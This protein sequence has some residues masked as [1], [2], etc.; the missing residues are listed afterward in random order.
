MNRDCQ[1]S[2]VS[3]L[4]R[5][6]SFFSLL[7]LVAVLLIL[8]AANSLAA[9]LLVGV[10]ET[11]IT[12]ERPVHLINQLTAKESE[13]VHQRLKA[14]AL[15]F[16]DPQ[17]KSKS[18]CVLIAFDG[19][20]VP[21]QVT[22]EVRKR[23]APR[24]P[25]QNVTVCATH[26]HCA[27]HLTGLLPG[28]F[29]DALPEAHQRRIDEYT[30]RLVDE[31]TGVARDAVNDCRPRRLLRGTGQVQFAVNRRKVVDG[32]WTGWGN[33]PDGA[34]DH[35]LPLLCVSNPDNSVAAILVSYACHNTS[36][37]G[38]NFDNRISGD[39]VGYA[40]KSIERNHPGAIA[41]VTLGCAGEARPNEHGGLEAARRFGDLIAG[42]VSRLTSTK[43]PEITT[44]PTCRMNLTRLSLSPPP[45]PLK[46]PALAQTA[47]TA[48]SRAAK[49]HA[50]I[51][52]DLLKQS[53]FNQAVPLTLDYPVQTWNFGS[54][55]TWVFL[56]GEV[57]VDYAHR[58]RREFGAT[59]WPIAYANDL[60]CYIPSKRILRE[61]GYE[62]DQSMAY[63]GRLQTLLPS[64]EDRIMAELRRQ[65]GAA[66]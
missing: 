34:V 23:L 47:A 10:A 43:L 50:R 48:R 5:G 56:A 14:K 11:D 4:R 49:A 42:E 57:V 41:M 26:D 31:L 28:I 32:R 9:S 38:R 1:F 2:S 7:Q 65:L 37:G 55:L 13:G 62:A 8:N 58:L 22:A 63:Y 61:G 15:A 33:D 64:T 20:G 6:A 52:A 44:P 17:S 21:P 53:E 30:K 39:W 3:T 66:R 36:I 12:P 24:I 40:Q 29:G 35:S 18:T 16:R 60:P 45:P 25:P 54:E 19:I 27:P 46:L 59:V 51:A